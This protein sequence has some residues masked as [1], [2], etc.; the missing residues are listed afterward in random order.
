VCHRKVA[1]S[2]IGKVLSQV[3]TRLEGSKFHVAA[4]TAWTS[5]FADTDLSN[6]TLRACI[7]KCL[8]HIKV[9]KGLSS[10]EWMSRVMIMVFLRNRHL[11][12]SAGD[13][14]IYGRGGP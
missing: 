3:G 8:T 7:E 11:S 10:Q 4:K 12:L 14:T 6:N 5:C 9:P 1:D 2:K 13:C